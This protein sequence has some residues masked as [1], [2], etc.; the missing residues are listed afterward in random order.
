LCFETRVTPP[1]IF[2]CPLLTTSQQTETLVTHT[3]QVIQRCIAFDASIVVVVQHL[4]VR[5]WNDNDVDVFLQEF[6][7]AAI[8]TSG[9]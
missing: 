7:V 4:V 2:K 5:H 9:N 1:S 3:T 8:L 6:M